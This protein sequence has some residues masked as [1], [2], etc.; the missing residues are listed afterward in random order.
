MQNKHPY[1]LDF[2]QYI[3][4][5]RAVKEGKVVCMVNGD[6]SATG[7]RSHPVEISF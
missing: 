5:R 6:W 7:G 3:P 2:E 4:Q 1:E